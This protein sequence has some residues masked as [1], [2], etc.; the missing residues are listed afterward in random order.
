MSMRQSDEAT[1]EKIEHNPKKKQLKS[2][3]YR[4]KNRPKADSAHTD[5]K[6]RLP[7][8]SILAQSILGGNLPETTPNKDDSLFNNVN[9][10][11]QEPYYIDKSGTKGNNSNVGSV[12]PANNDDGNE[13]QKKSSSKRKMGDGGEPV[14]TYSLPIRTFKAQE[15]NPVNGKPYR[16]LKEDDFFSGKY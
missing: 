15:T 3:K 6:Y 9:S 14:Q 10:D 4:N 12:K 11:I 13:V 2:P 5:G 16:S 7:A 1:L 8:F